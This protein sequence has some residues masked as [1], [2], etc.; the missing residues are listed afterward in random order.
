M[1]LVRLFLL[2]SL[3]GV[4]FLFA[5]SR[6]SAGPVAV[7]N[8]NKTETI[9]R[10]ELNDAVR[11]MQAQVRRMLTPQEKKLVLDNLIGQKLILQDA[12][13][14]KIRVSNEEV[15]KLGK[16]QTEAQLRTTL[17]DDQYRKIMKEQLSQRGVTFDQYVELMKKQLILQKY[18]QKIA[19]KKLTDIPP[20]SEAVIQQFYERN[21]AQFINPLYIRI[22]Q[23]F[24]KTIG[25]T[26]EEKKLL[27]KKAD[28]LYNEIQSGR[29][30]FE[31]LVKTDSDDK[32]SREKNGDVGYLTPN[33]PNVLKIYGQN[34]V[35]HVLKL[36][37]D[38][39]SRPIESNVGYHIIKATEH[40]EKHFLKL[41]DPIHP[42]VKITVRQ[43]ITQVLQQQ[44][45]A[46]RLQ[47]V[48]K[49]TASKLRRKADVTVYDKNID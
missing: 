8:L 28:R 16:K 44:E 47:E 48:L 9:S 13:R 1:K 22:S 12:D 10:K 31:D 39:V 33:D 45:Q 21:S 2:L 27:K 6:T 41:D 26:P 3:S 49:T 23:I 19:P 18:I 34:F 7:I 25:R 17:S 11:M 46:K 14:K 20:P 15:V 38:T 5:Q 29:A 43:R 37:K 30:G 36:K 40:R 35:D 4:P 32:V 24:L 42:S